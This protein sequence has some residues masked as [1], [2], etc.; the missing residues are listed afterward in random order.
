MFAAQRLPSLSLGRLATG[1][2]GAAGVLRRCGMTASAAPDLPLAQAVADRALPLPAIVGALEDLATAAG[3]RATWPTEDLI[4]Y[5]LERYHGGHRAD[6]PVL[7]ALALDL[8]GRA[9]SAPAPR[10]LADLIGAID[11]AMEEHMRKEELRVFPMMLRGRHERLTEWIAF[12]RREHE[13][14]VP[15]VLRLEAVTRG[16]RAPADDGLWLRFYEELERFVEDM[17]AHI[18]LEEQVLFRR[19]QA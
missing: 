17:V 12:L 18:Y 7:R 3:A 10:E 9:E 15:F 19:F 16:Y 6:I 8:A 11:L 5:I 1:L 4:A 2:P 13:D 14:A